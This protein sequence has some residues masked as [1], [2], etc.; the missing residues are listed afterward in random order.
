MS[1]ARLTR[2]SIGFAGGQ[3]LSVR[4]A[5]EALEGLNAALGTASP[6][7]DLELEDGTVRARARPDRLC[8]R[9]LR[10]AA[11]R[12]RSLT[13]PPPAVQSADLALLRFAR[14]AATPLSA[15]APSPRFSALGE[16]A[17]IWLALGAAASIFAPASRRG[18]GAPRRPRWPA[19]TSSTRR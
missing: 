12:L 18:A 19:P 8:A 4:V 5:A 3:V 7:F 15:S 13:A 6:W 16:H 17:A 10:R 11:R 2:A 1:P 14:T 9:R